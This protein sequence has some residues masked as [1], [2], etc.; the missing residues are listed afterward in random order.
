MA[1]RATRC[2]PASRLRPRRRRGGHRA[3]RGPP[4]TR[5][6]SPRF[7]LTMSNSPPGSLRR[8]AT[9][10]RLVGWVERSETHRS[11]NRPRRDGFRS[12]Q[13]ILHTAFIV[14]A[15]P[16]ARVVPLVFASPNRGE[17]ERR[18]GARVLR[19]PAA[20]HDAAR[21]GTWRGA[22]RVVATTRAPSR[23]STVA[24]Y[25]GSGSALP[26][27]AFPPESVQRRSSR[28]VLSDRRADSRASRACG[29][30]PQPRDATPASVFR[31]VSRNAPR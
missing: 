16:C 4:S 21:R 26:S 24:I 22:P 10:C 17:A 14:P 30:E 23:R 25:D 27:P 20:C 11:R 6:R 12:A 3:H 5:G 8:R 19:H 7:L 1:A 2:T 9:P 31:I 15:A 18:D 13:P 29:Y 28:P